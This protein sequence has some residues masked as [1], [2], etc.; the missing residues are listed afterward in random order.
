LKTVGDQSFYASGPRAWNSLPPSLRA[1]AL[2]CTDATPGS[3]SVLF[4]CYL[5]ASHSDGC[6]PDSSSLPATS[7]L[8]SMRKRADSPRGTVLA[9]KNPTSV[10]SAR[11][12]SDCS[13]LLYGEHFISFLLYGVYFISFPCCVEKAFRFETL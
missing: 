8:R 3:Y 5:L 9:I 4:R 7:V 1:C 2:A 13:H 10:N 12:L 6:S 11:S